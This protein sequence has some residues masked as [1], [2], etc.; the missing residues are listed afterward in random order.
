MQSFATTVTSLCLLAS[1][2][3]RAEQAKAPSGEVARAVEVT[4]NGSQPSAKAPADRFSGTVRIDPLFR[5]EEPSHLAGNSVTFEPSSRTA[6]HTHPRGQVLIVTAG[7]GWIQQWG[8]RAQEIKPG[9]VV[10]V[11][12]GQKHWHG[13]AATTAMTHISLQEQVDGRTADW[14]EKVSD[15]QYQSASAT[16]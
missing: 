12:P 1:A 14:M 8:G 15:E 6:W 5:P 4:R 16:R 9:D 11:P 13:A 7:S 10:R 3:A 2:I